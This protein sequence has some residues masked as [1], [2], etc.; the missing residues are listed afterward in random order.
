MAGDG[1]LLTRLA[2][3]LAAVD[4]DAL[5]ALSSVGL[6]RRARKDLDREPV[7]VSADDGVVRVTLGD[8]TVTMTAAG[9]ADAR[10]T[11]PAGTR[12]RHVLI[13]TLFLKANPPAATE[14]PPA[15]DVAAELV[16]YPTDALVRWVGRKT[17]NDAAKLLAGSPDA[18]VV[19]GTG[20]TV[21]FPS[22]GVECRYFPG[23]GLA[24]MVTTAPAKARDR[25][26]AAA[27]LAVRRAR[28]VAVEGPSEPA[29]VVE[30]AAGSPRTRAEVV[31]AARRLLEE[32]VTVGLA[33][34]S[35]SVRDRLRTLAVSCTGCDL[36]R[37]SLSL[38]AMA[39]AVERSLRR[40][41]AADDVALFSLA[42]RTYALCAALAGPSPD[43]VGRHRSRYDVTGPLDLTGVAAYAWR[44][45]S[46]YRGL[47]VLFWDAVA[48]AFCSWS[49]SRPLA[50]DASFDPVARYEQ[51][52]PWAGATSARGMSRAR[53]RLTDA[54]RN[55]QGRLGS[56]ERARAAL[57]GDADVAGIDFGPRGF[58]DWS[59][60]R[61]H[62][63]AVTP[64]GL[65]EHP[66]LD[67]M[68]VVRPSG[69][70]PRAFVAAEQTLV[71]P[72]LDPA[73]D[74]VL[75]T[76]PF[77]A[78]TARAVDALE[79]TDPAA[80]E[81]WGVVGRVGF[82]GGAV[83]LW[84]YALVH[85]GRPVRNLNLDAAPPS[86]GRATA[87]ANAARGEDETVDDAGGLSGQWEGLED[88]VQRMA[89]SGV[90][91]LSVERQRLTALAA[92]LAD[93]GFPPLA[94]S[95]SRLTEPGTAATA[96]LRLGYTCAA[97]RGTAARRAVTGGT[98]ARPE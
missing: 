3:V 92:R 43:L 38:R 24:G 94:A 31:A 13:A 6:V 7:T 76:L 4:D 48:G 90:R 67:R 74:A 34:P 23:A 17:F 2:A 72:L 95:V 88:D 64:V 66:P 61:H 53:F 78:T 46:G 84:P 39:D 36:P 42:C 14:P 58:T 86:P 21:R 70:G 82:A 91:R 5:A 93:R 69:W 62:L 22:A 10:C 40:D 47:T 12:C 81:P 57:L 27:V 52:L 96:V 71:W 32:M 87:A 51:D 98:A 33:H 75:L 8:G 73:G 83:R 1:D 15:I 37:L 55:D 18:V 68:V 41:A 60:L 63:A 28:G 80:D 25:F 35:G 85:A 65:A 49:D 45:A 97:Y 56:S 44:T 79:A 26:L 30:P 16:A 20:V 29:A 59:A 77:D 19:E 89:E 9:P 50:R 11:C 54:S